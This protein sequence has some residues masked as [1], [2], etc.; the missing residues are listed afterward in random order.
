MEVPTRWPRVRVAEELLQIG[1]V[2]AQAGGRPFL[3]GGWPRDILRTHLHLDDTPHRTTSRAT[4]RAPSRSTDRTEADRDSD[5]VPAQAP[6]QDAAP[7]SAYDVEV[8]A[9]PAAALKQILKRF[10]YVHE[11]GRHFGVL[12]LRSASA[13][14]DFSLPRTETKIG[15]GHRGFR[16][17]TDP[18]LTYASAAARR[19]VT[20]NSI[21]YAF[22]E[23]RWFDPYHGLDDLQRRLLRHVGPAFAEDPLR[24]LRLM[25]FAARFRFRIH[26]GTLAVCRQQDLSELPRERI[27]E[28][29]KKC[30]L[31]ASEPAYGLRYLGAL[32]ALPAFPALAALHHPHGRSR[33]WQITLK[34][35][36]LAAT[37]Y[38]RRS[39]PN[40]PLLRPPLLEPLLPSHP[41]KERQQAFLTLM[42][43]LL[44]HAMPRSMEG[45]TGG[46]SASKRRRRRGSSA[47]ADPTG[48]ATAEAATTRA[49]TT[50]AVLGAG[51][52][53]PKGIDQQTFLEQLIDTPRWMESITA[54][55]QHW[56]AV[57][58]GAGQPEGVVR[59]LALHSSL[60]LLAE[61]AVAL[62]RARWCLGWEAPAV[63]RSTLQAAAFLRQAE[64]LGVRQGPPEPLL[65]GRHLQASGLKPGP[66]LGRILRSSFARQLDGQFRTLEEILADL[67]QRGIL[68]STPHEDPQEERR[69][70]GAERC[71]ESVAKN[72]FYRNRPHRTVAGVLG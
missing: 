18:Q 34:A 13:E 19:D 45:R 59:R 43:A 25:Q 31:Q 17:C 3:V 61:V 22:L 21:G 53:P 1:Q 28:E 2:I 37:A 47:N 5:S 7:A 4:D 58:Q 11:V 8:F 57:L 16:V 23:E 66:H 33:P 70:K 26:P 40:L 65:K 48:A 64:R 14:Y 27:W 71:A 44:T 10:G 63:D 29:F 36:D 24:V 42:L 46:R 35:L 62:S 39:P 51:V 12:K 9:L 52:S 6:I 41:A 50:R 38:H 54:L 49:A 20:I 68:P 67:R 30:L 55:T 60:P 15:P 72:S 56:P 32:G 69:K